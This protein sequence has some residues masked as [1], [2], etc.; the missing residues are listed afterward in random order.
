MQI[1]YSNMSFCFWDTER[2]LTWCRKQLR[3]PAGNRLSLR[4]RKWICSPCARAER[5]VR[6]LTKHFF[7]SFSWTLGGGPALQTPPAITPKRMFLFKNVLY[8]NVKACTRHT[9]PFCPQP[10]CRDDVGSY[11]ISDGIKSP[12]EEE[13]IDERKNQWIAEW[14]TIG[15]KVDTWWWQSSWNKWWAGSFYSN[16]QRRP[17]VCNVSCHIRI[18]LFMHEIMCICVRQSF[19]H[20]CYIK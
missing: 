11:I 12:R 2:A 1:V 20:L 16:R 19:K 9:N 10:C 7:K 17:P 6:L 4:D 13:W 5:K 15:L 3:E 8:L 18:N 14:L